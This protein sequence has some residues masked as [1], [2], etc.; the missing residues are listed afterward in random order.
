MH[1]IL[2]LWVVSRFCC[3][4]GSVDR[5]RKVSACK[6]KTRRSVKSRLW[7]MHFLQVAFPHI[8]EMV[9]CTTTKCTKLGVSPINSSWSLVSFFTVIPYC[10]LVRLSKIWLFCQS[11]HTIKYCFLI[12]TPLQKHGLVKVDPVRHEKSSDM[13]LSNAEDWRN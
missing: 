5:S 11:P 9:E 10:I 2:A 4:P 13:K 3:R 1:I 12:V 6:Y 8:L 7:E